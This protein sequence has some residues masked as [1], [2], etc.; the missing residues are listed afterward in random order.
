[1][2]ENFVHLIDADAGAVEAKYKLARQKIEVIER[3]DMVGGRS[4]R[5][6]SLVTT[7]TGYLRERK[8]VTI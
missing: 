5:R 4:H 1:M 3:K 2:D 7:L 8:L 6:T